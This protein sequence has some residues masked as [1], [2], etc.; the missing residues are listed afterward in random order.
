VENL[1][2][3]KQLLL[4]AI[5]IEYVRFAEPISSDALVQKYDLG[6]KSATVR[7]ELAEM[8]DMGLL[9][10]PH[11]SAGR[12]PSDSGYRFYVDHLIIERA[13]EETQKLIDKKEIDESEVLQDMLRDT[14]K[15]LSRA[16]QQLSVATMT[17]DTNLKVVTALISAIGPTQALLVVALNNGH[18]ENRLIECP[19]NLTLEDIGAVNDSLR[20]KIVGN[21][22]GN[23]SKAKPSL[24]IANPAVEKLLASIFSHL[25][26]ISKNLTRGKVLTEGEEFL[27]AKPEFHHDSLGLSE[28]FRQ[29]VESDVLYESVMPH[30]D[31]VTIGK[32]NKSEQMQRFSVVRRNYSIG[33]NE[34][35]VV[36]LVGPTRMDYEVGIPLVNFTANALSRSLTK[37]FG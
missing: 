25:R 17:K 4:K 21:T 24:M 37:F 33:P 29:L 26:T 13:I 35:G 19:K 12:I 32:E 27:F 18:V 28:L 31:V 9:E 6:V 1:D 2:T 3:R 8:V 34:I 14:L 10:Q 30:T 20:T 7:N 36:G 15:V 22:L 5:V 16:T 11:T 23:L